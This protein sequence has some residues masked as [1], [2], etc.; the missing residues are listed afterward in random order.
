MYKKGTI[1]IGNV[2]DSTTENYDDG[3]WMYLPHSCDSWVIGGVPEALEL[4]ADLQKAIVTLS[5]VSPSPE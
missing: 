1:E 4:I 2:T 5:A 3:N